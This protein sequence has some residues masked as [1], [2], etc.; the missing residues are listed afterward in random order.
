MS[1]GAGL[2]VELDAAAPALLADVEALAQAGVRTGASTRNWA[3]YGEAVRIDGDL[4]QWRRDL[5]TDP[6]TSGGLLIA[7][8]ADA[9]DALLELAAERGFTASRVVGRVVAGPASVVIRL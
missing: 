3:S 5:L 1:R 9:A 8:A 6:Q 4:P 2:T 7:V